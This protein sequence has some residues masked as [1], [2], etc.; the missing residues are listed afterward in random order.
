MAAFRPGMNG[1]DP[2]APAFWVPFQSITEGNHIAQWVNNIQRQTCGTGMCANG[3]QCIN[4]RCVAP[5]P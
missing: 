5:P 2:S 1:P 3:E 4:G